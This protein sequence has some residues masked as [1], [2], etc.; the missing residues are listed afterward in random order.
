MQGVDLLHVQVI[1][2]TIVDLFIPAIKK[3]SEIDFEPA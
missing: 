2:L 3:K 1:I